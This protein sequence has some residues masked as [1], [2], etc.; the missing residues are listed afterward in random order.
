[1]FLGHYG[2]ALAAKRVAPDLSLGGAITAAML[3]D[4]IWPICLLL[5]LEHVRVVPRLLVGNSFDFISYPISHSLAASLGWAALSGA[6]YYLVRRD[7]KS[8][9]VVSVLVASHWWLDVVMHRPDMPLWPGSGLRWGLGAWGSIPATLALEWGSLAVGLGVYLRATEPLDRTGARAL[10]GLV[11][12]LGVSWA[13]SQALV[14]PDSEV[15]IA[16]EMIALW[17][18]AAWGFWIDRH[19]AVRAA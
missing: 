7:R 14:P 16:L 3:L 11:A 19:R 6:I 1:M 13:F 9:L 10:W 17:P 15:G 8:A 12:A 4:A 18:F 5:G 2:E